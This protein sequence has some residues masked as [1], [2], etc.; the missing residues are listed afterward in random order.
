MRH[1]TAAEMRYQVWAALFEGARGLFFY[2]YAGSPTPN[3]DG[4]YDEHFLDHR[5]R[6]LPHYEEA[7]RISRDLAPLKPLLLRLRHE[8]EAEIV[9]WENRPQM[10]GRTFVH[11]QTGG[12]YLMTFNSD[13]EREQPTDLE[14]GYFQHYLKW[15]DRL[16]DLL[17]GDVHDGQSLRQVM[18]PA[19]SGRIYLIG[20]NADW[21]RHRSWS[22]TREE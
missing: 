20:Q 22:A 11:E 6:P 19:G 18:L 14:L 17:T 3:G 4:Y 1:P 5:G 8:P 10:H 9:Y 15:E 12:R 2:A 13:V 7:A 16:Y 21:Q